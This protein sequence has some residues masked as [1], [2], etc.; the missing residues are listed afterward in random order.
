MASKSPQN[1]NKKRKQPIVGLKRDQQRPLFGSR[2]LQQPPILET[3]SLLDTSNNL[4]PSPTKENTRPLLRPQHRQTFSAGRSLAAAYNAT[5]QKNDENQPPS[6]AS[7]SDRTRHQQSLKPR[8]LQAKRPQQRPASQPP[9]EKQARLRTP[10]PASPE[11]GR[12]LSYISPSSSASSPPRGLAEAY[13]RIVDEENLAQDESME[14]ID[15]HGYQLQSSTGEVD[16]DRQNQGAFHNV[17]SSLSLKTSRRTSPNPISRSSVYESPQ[18]SESDVTKSVQEDAT[19]VSGDLGPSQRAKDVRRINGVLKNDRPFRKALVGDRVGLTAENLRRRNGSTDSLGSAFGGSVSSRG[20]DPSVNVPRQWGR[21][22]KPGKDW[23]SRINSSSGRF[24]GDIPKRRSPALDTASHMQHDDWVSTAADIPLP[25]GEDGSSQAALSSHSSTPTAAPIQNQSRDRVLDWDVQDDDFTGRSLQMSDSPPIR[26]RNSTL[27]RILEKEIASVAK[28]AVTTSRLDEIREKRSEEN[29]YRTGSGTSRRSSDYSNDERS[30]LSLKHRHLSS[31]KTATPG[32]LQTHQGEAIPDT[33]VVVYRS[34]SS[35]SRGNESEGSGNKSR[36]SILRPKSQRQDS[37]GL[38]KQLAQ[39]TSSSPS[40]VS[41]FEDARKPTGQPTSE[42]VDQSITEDYRDSKLD[43]KHQ[44][45]NHERDQLLEPAPKIEN[46]DKDTPQPLKS[47][48][49]LKTPQVM[50][51]WIDTPFPTGGRGPPMPTPETNNQEAPF[52][53]YNDA[54]AIVAPDLIRKLSPHTT[55]TQPSD[56][57]LK[58]TAPKLPKSA[59]ESIISAAKARLDNHKRPARSTELHLDPEEDATL[60]LGDSTI[61][62]LEELLDNGTASDMSRKPDPATAATSTNDES[63]TQLLKELPPGDDADPPTSTLRLYAR[64]LSR[65][66]FL[67]P[68]LRETRAGIASLERSISAPT[69][70]P[71]SAKSSPP[72]LS[73]REKTE[74]TEAGE[75]HDFIS[76]CQTCGCPGPSAS[77][78]SASAI[79]IPI[80]MLWRR[81]HRGQWLPRPTR[82][83]ILVLLACVYWIAELWAQETY[84][85][86]YY[87]SSMIGYGVD[88]HAPKRPFVLVKVVFGQWLALGKI[89]RVLVKVVAGIMGWAVGFVAGDSEDGGRAGG[90]SGTGTG[91]GTGRGWKN[92]PMPS[93]GPDLSMMDDEVM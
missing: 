51:A 36:H 84:C 81:S 5:P 25:P 88:I 12:Q 30:D 56:E 22:A 14:N 92:M 48:T 83:G 78:F 46:R 29:I 28:K 23:L 6:S 24:T 34:D 55:Q 90:T 33:P 91:V 54:Q 44:A 53:I 26:I 7:S 19:E 75:F 31:S 42:R 82:L 68:S 60:L 71:A 72:Q 37:H 85:H 18:E 17:S 41:E 20:S 64:Q 66:N 40:P 11:R 63:T 21:K 45:S 27:D 65:L 1:E 93:W 62:S 38:L 61:H 73:R 52:N 74:C 4:S 3:E 67:L 9:A 49:Y 87:A 10:S 58:K 69:P 77:A 76:P 43:M 35:G 59:L 57:E 13:Q 47:N 50:G 2:R 32:P 39:A 89:V 86:K 8:P 15:E 70:F 79:T 16:D 80:P